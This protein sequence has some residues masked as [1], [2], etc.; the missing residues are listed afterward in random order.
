MSTSE[1]KPIVFVVDDDA[2]V[3]S[4]FKSLLQSVNLD[5]EVFGSSEEFLRRK[6]VDTVSCLILDIRM[7]GPSGLDLQTE[8][9]RTHH[10]IPI[11]FITG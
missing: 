3:R 10:D 1:K 7:P 4:G 8:L 2:D 11:I 5:C 6:P 9:A